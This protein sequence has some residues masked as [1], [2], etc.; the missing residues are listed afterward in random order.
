MGVGPFAMAGKFLKGASGGRGRAAGGASGGRGERREGRAAGGGKPLP[1]GSGITEAEARKRKGGSGRAGAE[2]RAGAAGRQREGAAGRLIGRGLREGS[3]K[4]AGRQREGAS[5]SRT[6]GI[7]KK[8][9]GRFRADRDGP[10]VLL[11][12]PQHPRGGAA[13]QKRVEVP[14][15]RKVLAGGEVSPVRV[16]AG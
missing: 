6:E 13:K 16:D 8:E 12:V 4:A 7:C 1:Y 3:G 2:A 11:L 14:I 5:P 15:G 10:S 9:K